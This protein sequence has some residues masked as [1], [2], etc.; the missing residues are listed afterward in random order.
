MISPDAVREAL[1]GP[2]ASLSV[3]F[4]KDGS[5]DYR[6]LAGLIDRIIAAGSK[7]VILTYGDSLYSVLSDQE[8]ADVTRSVAGH[9]AGRAMVV[10]ADRQW[11]TGR[12]V[13]FARYAGDVGADV[14]MVLPPTWGGSCTE[15]TLVDHYARVAQE[16]PVM[17]VTGL[18]ANAHELGFSVLRRLRDEVDGVV[19]VKEDAGP[20]FARKM[21]LLVHDKWAVFAG[22]QKQNHLNMAPYGCDGYMSTFIKF[23]PR[24]AHDYW[25]AVEVRDWEGARDLIVDYD[26]PYFDFVGTLPGRFDAGVHGV[27]ELYGIAKRW[28]REPYHSLS[29]EEMEKLGGFFR[30]RGWL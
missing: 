18:F 1:T 17:V 2:V 19:A 12:T 22:G 14:L 30:S 8:V 20:V 15:D 5:I 13:E 21:C 16:M 7:S 11:W 24:V 28:R 4:E 3:T 6:G 26:M 27:Y 25:R 9:V 29:D 10:A 23:L